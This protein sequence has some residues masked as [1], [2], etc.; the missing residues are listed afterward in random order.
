MPFA[1]LALGACLLMTRL[2][3]RVSLQDVQQ[4]GIEAFVERTQHEPRMAVR[5]SGCCSAC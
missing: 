4:E 5:A 2:S 3:R 1:A